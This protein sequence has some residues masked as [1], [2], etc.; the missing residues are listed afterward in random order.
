MSIISS[1]SKLK[2]V[3]LSHLERLSGIIKTILQGTAE[4]GTGKRK[5]KSKDWVVLA[6]Q[7][8]KGQLK[9]NL[10][11]EKQSQSY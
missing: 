10:N 4:E 8:H 1:I 5:D 7:A 11:G 9:T 2:T 3:Y 6:L